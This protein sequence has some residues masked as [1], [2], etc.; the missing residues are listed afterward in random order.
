MVLPF[1]APQ[2]PSVV[3]G[4]DT[5]LEELEGLAVALTDV[6]EDVSEDMPEVKVDTAET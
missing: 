1:W 4:P 6:S 3:I 2:L 5:G